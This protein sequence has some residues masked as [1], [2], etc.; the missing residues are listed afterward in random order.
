MAVPIQ[1][2]KIGREDLL[3][4]LILAGFLSP[5]LMF[6][7]YV[8]L[9]KPTSPF[10]EAYDPEFAY[11]MNSLEVFKGHPYAYVDHPGTPLEILG[12]L[13]YASIYPFLHLAPRDFVLYNL[14]HPGLFLNICH[15]FLTLGSIACAVTFFRMASPDKQ[16]GSVL[17]GAALATSYFVLHPLSFRFTSIWSH[18]SF[19]F[20]GG[21][22]L[23]LLLF[24]ALDHPPVHEV[25][26]RQLMLLGLGGGL[27]AGVTIYLAAWVVGIIAAV[28]INYR[29]QGLSWERTLRALARIAA[30]SVA[31]FGLIML[32]VISTGSYFFGWALGLVTHANPYLGSAGTPILVRMGSNL[33]D[34]STRAPVLMLVIA[35]FL[36]GTV[37]TVLYSRRSLQQHPGWTGIVSG[38]GVQCAL[39]LILLLNDYSFKYSL[40][41]AAIVPVWALAFYKLYSDTSRWIRPARWLV[42]L[43]VILGLVTGL[44]DQVAD[45]RHDASLV[46]ARINLQNSAISDYAA[47][48]G[49]QAEDVMVL[50]TYG[51]YSP[52][53]ALWIGNNRTG[54]AFDEEI[55]SLCP[56][57][58]FYNVFQGGVAYLDSVAGRTSIQARFLDEL[59]WDVYLGCERAL[60][61]DP[62]FKKAAYVVTVP[63]P[64]TSVSCGTMRPDSHFAIAQRR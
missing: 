19:A 48:T 54:S 39:L 40:A 9:F 33:Q 37:L 18:N 24:K 27:L 25:S 6:W 31:G 60:L 2:T 56:D 47:R 36:C 46:R 58:H 42:A 11:L 26:T 28:L 64:P 38:L 8:H 57:F 35:L 61:Q 23:L 50:W 3:S 63:S 51:T 12:T 30:W 20:I 43:A 34:L 4:G 53:V 7:V 59:D 14:Q 15:A 29:L 13:F 5:I 49:K 62:A 55:D 52:C 21:T 45:Y 44:R 32:P 10:F 1:T 22:L 41:L 16:I 17:F